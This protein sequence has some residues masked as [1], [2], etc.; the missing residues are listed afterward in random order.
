MPSG[1][2]KPPKVKL[3]ASPLDPLRDMIRDGR[4]M[5]ED[6]GSDIRSLADE[7]HASFP[8]SMANTMMEPIPPPQIETQAATN[9]PR[10]GASKITSEETVVYQKK[11]IAKE[12][13]QLEK[14]LAQGCRIPDKDGKRIPCDCCQKGTFVSGLA[15][16]TIP[17]AERI[18]QSSNIYNEIAA[19]CEELDTKVTVSAI[20]NGRY[21]YKKLSGEA[22]TLRK[23]LMGTLALSA[24]TDNPGH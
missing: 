5:I 21:D 6:A 10:A 3:P 2:F 11:E 13:W 15:Y 14:H 8:G 12:L 17:I 4:G 9:I 22:S 19:W 23:K 24:M 1:P 7:F 20:E 16:E 18:G